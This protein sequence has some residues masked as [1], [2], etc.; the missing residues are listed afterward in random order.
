MLSLILSNQAACKLVSFSSLLGP[1]LVSGVQPCS[2][3]FWVF[4]CGGG[5]GYGLVAK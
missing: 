1:L 4:P 5:G 3:N 2:L